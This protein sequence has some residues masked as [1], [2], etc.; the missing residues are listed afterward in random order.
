MLPET[1]ASEIDNAL[2]DLPEFGIAL[3][4]GSDTPVWFGAGANSSGITMEIVPWLGRFGER[5]V[6]GSE[7]HH[8]EP[9]AAEQA[10][11]HSTTREEYMRGV[12]EV[13]GSCRER[14]GKTV[15]SRVI[16]GGK[17]R[18]TYGTIAARLF[19]AHPDTLRFIYRTPETGCWMGATPE[20]L[21][22]YHRPTRQLHT[23]AFAG[24]R[25]AGTTAEWDRKNVEENRFVVDFITEALG[26]LATNV[27]VHD[28]EN[29]TYGSIEHLC[30]RITARAE[31]QMLEEIAD[32]LNPT[33]ALCGWPRYIAIADIDRCELHSRECYGGF[34][35]FSHAEGYSAFVNLRS[36]Q[37]SAEGFRIFGGGGI[38]GSSIPEEE[39]AETE[40]KTALLQ[41]LT[42][43]KDS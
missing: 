20:L 39:F 7:R 24:T 27:N 30:H 8:T 29:V 25:P 15:Y 10:A 28:A 32:A 11:W 22:D 19:A 35:G 2:A 6:I 43:D 23:M 12:G 36:M 1:L 9:I 4:P 18:L 14:G 3:F 41:K 16:A 38:T 40:A 26:R 42:A 17:P 13:I 34:I 21:F 5:M 33:P 31:P 37:F